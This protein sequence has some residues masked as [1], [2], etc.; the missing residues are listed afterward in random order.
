MAILSS[1]KKSVT[2]Q[3]GDT[4]SQIALDYKSYSNNASYQKLAEIND[5]SN[6][7][8]IYV[9]QVIKLTGKATSSSKSSSSNKATINAFGLQS[10]SDNT[11]FAT[12]KWTKKKTEEYKTVWQYATGDG[13]WFYISDT[14]T[15]Y[16]QSTCNIP[17]NATKV[18][19]RVKPV[20][21]KKTNSKGKE[22]SHWTAEW[23]SWKQ[24]NISELPPVAPSVP[25][26]E[27]KK[28]KLIA[29]ID[30]LDLDEINAT[31]IKF[32][33]VKDDKTSFKTGIVTINKKF[34][35]VSYVCNVDAGHNYKVRC[36]SIRNKSQSE[37]TQFSNN[38]QAIPSVPS[39]ITKCKASGE[40]ED[41]YSVYLEWSK[42]YSAD[43]YD[44]EYTTNKKYFDNAGDTTTVST[45]E[46]VTKFTIYKLASGEYFFRV[47]AT[48][49]KGSSDWSGIKSVK[50]GEPPSAPTTWSSTTTV[51]VGEP[52]NLYWVHNAE[53]G[54]SQTWA[55]VEITANGKTKTY[56]VENTTDLDEK[57]KTS[58]YPVDTTQFSEGTQLKWRVRTA[59]VTR[60]LG[61]WSIQRV[62]D[63][64]APATLTLTVTNEYEIAEDGSITLLEPDGGMNT[65]NSFPFY[66]KAVAG[67]STQVPIGYHLTV[68]ARESYETIDQIG[69]TKTVSEGDEVYSKYFDIST[70]F[71]VELSAGNI[72]LENGIEYEIKC[73]VS[74]N[75]GLTAEASSSFTVDWTDTAYIPNAEISIDE[76]TYSA[77]I[78]AYCAKGAYFKVIDPFNGDGTLSTNIKFEMLDDSSVENIESI[79][80]S[81]G[82]RVYIGA[83][84]DD[85]I[86][87]FIYYA[88]LHFD[89]EGFPIDP[90]YR[91]VVN[92]SNIFELTDTVLGYNF[93]TDTSMGESWSDIS[94]GML[95]GEDIFYCV[96]EDFGIIEGV[97]LSV[98]RRDFD[99]S[100]TE[101]ATG[102]DNTRNTFVTDPHPALD[103]AR[104]RI[105]ATTDSTGAVGYY[106]V[107]GYLVGG[108]AA[109]IQWAEEWSSFENWSEDT[110]AEPSWTGSILKLPY[111]IDVSDSNDPDVTLVEYIG[112]KRPVTYYGT[113]LGE[114]STWN[115]AI[116]KSDEETLYLLRRL[117]IWAGD[118]YVREP[119]GS[120]YWANI[121]VSFSQKHCELTI[122]VTLD[123]TRVEGGM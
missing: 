114:K 63:I 117:A 85:G 6:P 84:I 8:R 97:S 19:F 35:Y 4:L 40:N 109:I 89:D 30:N 32:E 53:D 81:T 106:D 105:V 108:K 69:L 92:N 60:T 12:W 38:E 91:Q 93:F 50:I 112:R 51:T 27:I 1:D 18:R 103:Y 62:V 94:L 10:N 78:R 122:P 31:S 70:V 83:K 67:P 123:I 61:D 54:S 20:S 34:N 57:D 87:H 95:N 82:E 42:V 29:T 15:K 71:L 113:Q 118:V 24:Y 21:K 119:S 101:I 110:L 76:D 102:L 90:V 36:R 28:Y 39:K 13:V 49:E 59:G 52:L 73:I 22:T 33:V 47:R 7:N 3:K 2:V 23:S 115:V 45:T 5:I 99:G 98:Y 80:T 88:V 120:G 111:N 11:L 48:N 44:I 86:T 58:V 121:K 14:T 55:R 64:N 43:T 72:D 41:G 65:L 26:I 25:S 116:E 79:Y 46:A 75:S 77:S 96:R 74:M 9:G 107:P 68:I 104:Y 66:I 16:K 37:W 56:D 17:D 100:F